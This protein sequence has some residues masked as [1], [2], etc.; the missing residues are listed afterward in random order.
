MAGKRRIDITVEDSLCKGT[1]GCGLCIHVCP[2]A[3]YEKAPLTDRGLKPPAPV[4][5]DRCTGCLL[6]MMYCPDF[7]IVVEIDGVPAEDTELSDRRL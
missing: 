7:A 5:A 6:C 3:V 4:N 2:K 1:D